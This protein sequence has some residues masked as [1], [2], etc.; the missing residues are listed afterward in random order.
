MKKIQL[1]FILA[2]LFMLEAKAQKMGIR[3]GVSLASAETKQDINVDNIIGYQIGL[4]LDIP[5]TNNLSVDAS[6]LYVRRGYKTSGPF[7]GTTKINYLDV[8]IDIVYKLGISN[9]DVLLIGG[10]YFSYAFNATY[11]PSTGVNID[12]FGE[13]GSLKRID[14]GINLGLGLQISKIR[15]AFIHGLGLYNLSDIDSDNIKSRS[16]KLSGQ[17]YF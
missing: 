1:L 3:G 11:D 15:I 9:F 17:L 8:P 10:P 7:S 12:L 6:A 14:S 13:D 5:L 4:V 16:Y 2:S